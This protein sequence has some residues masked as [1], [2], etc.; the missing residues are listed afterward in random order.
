ML[1]SD[2]FDELEHIKNVDPDFYPMLE[3][4]FRIERKIVKLFAGKN[5][6]DHEH[7]EQVLRDEGRILQQRV[8]TLEHPVTI[9]PGMPGLEELTSRA[10][11][12]MRDFCLHPTL[13][14]AYP[15]SSYI[16]PDV[17]KIWSAPGI[18]TGYW[19]FKNDIEA[20]KIPFTLL[21]ASSTETPIYT[22]IFT[23]GY[24]LARNHT[25]RIQL[26]SK[27]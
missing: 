25:Q 3:K 8:Y 2:W 15:V 11:D 10:A 22:L 17:V 18:S 13:H 6:L 26:A 1:K 16:D 21:R 27:K 9:K 14:I 20:Q 12:A 5:N 4:Q 23:F 19:R 24:E 7:A